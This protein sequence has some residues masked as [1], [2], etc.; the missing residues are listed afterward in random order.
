M[1]YLVQRLGIRISRGWMV[2]ILIAGSLVGASY[3]IGPLRELPPELQLLAVSD[4]LALPEVSLQ[5]VPKPDGG[6]RFALP[7]A[8]RNIG[9]QP[10]RPSH[11]ALSVPAHLRV[12]TRRGDV[13]GE[14]SPGVPLRRYLL[15]VASPPVEP[16]NMSRRLPGLDTVWIEADLPAYYCTTQ[17]GP[18]PEFIPAPQH[19]TRTLSD[20]RVFYSFEMPDPDVRNTGTLVLHLDQQQLSSTPAPMPPAFPAIFEEPEATVPE[21][22]ELREAGKRT[23]LCGDP[24]QPLELYTVLWETAAGGRFYIIYYDGAERKHLYD[25]NGDDI[26]E[27]ETW[28]ADGD[29]LFEARREAR[30]AV[31][32][33]LKPVETLDESLLEPDTMPAKAEFVALFDRAGLGPWRF[34]RPPKP[35]TMRAP[36]RDSTGALIDSTGARI[37]TTRIVADSTRARPDS[38]TR[39]PA[40]ATPTPTGLGPLPPGDRRFVRLFTDTASGPFRFT[41]PAALAAADS[42]VR[43]DSLARAAARARALRNAVPK[44][45]GTPIPYPRPDT[46]RVTTGG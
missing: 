27:L 43:A 46:G 7:L 15:N 8:V 34:A 2:L 17:G 39:I 13:D 44:P 26:V 33:F 42:A 32:S 28:D 18:V 41:R 5:G 10:G 1:G 45:L 37:D 35:D 24:E 21:L 29:G 11:L 36:L 16:S 22:G 19:D 23:S 31:P 12:V 6:V 9:A 30:Y 20:V 25:L 40:V 3:W 38:T 4:S 14:V